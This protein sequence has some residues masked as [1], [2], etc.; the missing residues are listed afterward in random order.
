MCSL[1]FEILIRV[2]WVICLCFFR[3]QYFCFIQS[4]VNMFFHNLFKTQS[5]QILHLHKIFKYM[6]LDVIFHFI[7]NLLIVLNTNIF[8]NNLLEWFLS[9]SVFEIIIQ[10]PI[11]CLLNSFELIEYLYIKNIVI[12]IYLIFCEF[13]WQAIQRVA[14]EVWL[15]WVPRLR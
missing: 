4:P 7:F 3:R 10:R 2:C 5:L 8:I 11:N 1:T 14:N 6:F 9:K 15:D 13:I 12:K